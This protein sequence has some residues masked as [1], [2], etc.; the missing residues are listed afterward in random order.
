[1]AA[2]SADKALI[3]TMHHPALSADSLHGGSSYMGGV[4]DQAIQSSGRIP[5]LVAAGHVHNYQRFTRTIDGRQVPYLVAGAGGY[6]HLHPVAGDATGNPPRPP[7][8]VPGMQGT[9]DAYVDDRHGYLRVTA[10]ARALQVDYLTEPR[11]QESWQHG[12]TVVADSFTVDLQ[13]SPSG[14]VG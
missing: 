2:A 10:S 11:P 9:L 14:T 5:D 13:P 7:W 4:L 12:P 6:W 8:P 3:L 1:L